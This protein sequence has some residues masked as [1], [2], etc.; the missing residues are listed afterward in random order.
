MIDNRILFEDLVIHFNKPPDRRHNVNA[1]CPFCG[2]DKKHFAFSPRGYNCFSCQASGSLY[3]LFQHL[4][5]EL[6]ES[7]RTY[8]APRYVQPEPEEQGPPA[9]QNHAPELIAS[10]T[11]HDQTVTQWQRYKAILKSETIERWRFG[12]GTLPG[13]S[14]TRLI[15]PVWKGAQCVA[16]HGRAISETRGPKWICAKGSNKRMPWGVETL[17]RGAPIFVV[18]NYV[19]AALMHQEQPGWGVLAMGSARPWNATMTA[20]L[21]RYGPEIVVVAYDN[22]LVGNARDKM[23]EQLV[24]EFLAKNP[25]G[26]PPK[27]QGARSVAAMRQAGINAT[28]FPW[29]EDAPPKADPFWVLFERNN[30]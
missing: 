12:L 6:P 11:S 23:R 28:M 5:L 4:Q 18:E 19:D 25:K 20:W 21:R 10:Y 13:Q 22:D 2:K 17:Q 15:V 24:A 8:Q 3:D 14:T 9:W 30:V 16:L 7:D 26:N 29:P 27:S 1:D